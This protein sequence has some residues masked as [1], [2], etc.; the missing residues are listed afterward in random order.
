MKYTQILA[1]E[2]QIN[3]LMDDHIFNMKDAVQTDFSTMQILA[4]HIK[5][6]MTHP[7][8]KFNHYKN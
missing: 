1:T 6:V 8:K 3:H 5:G 4:W 2:S 7:N